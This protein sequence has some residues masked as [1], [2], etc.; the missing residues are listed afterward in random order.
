MRLNTVFLEMARAQLVVFDELCD[1]LFVDIAMAG[2]ELLLRDDWCRVLH[3][4]IAAIFVYVQVLI[5]TK[6]ASFFR[7]WTR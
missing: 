7:C 3:Y 2:D 4:A 1:I 6:V 5:R